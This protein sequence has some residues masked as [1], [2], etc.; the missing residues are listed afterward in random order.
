LLA[1]CQRAKRADGAV[2]GGSRTGRGWDGCGRSPGC[3]PDVAE[4]GG[5]GGGCGGGGCRGGCADVDGRMFRMWR[6]CECANVGR[7]CA[8]VDTHL[9][10]TNVENECGHPPSPNVDT[11]FS[12]HFPTNFPRMWISPDVRMSAG[13]VGCVGCGHPLLHP[14]FQE[15]S[16]GPGTGRTRDTHLS[17]SHFSPT[18]H[19]YP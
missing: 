1:T 17:S 18:L 7:E 6:M 11:H 4:C 13:C 12:A 15:R 9:P 5:P 16:G 19:V 10:R 8:N 3:G 14:F 2:S